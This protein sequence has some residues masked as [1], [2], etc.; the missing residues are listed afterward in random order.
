MTT[1]A[2]VLFSL[3]N[4]KHGANVHQLSTQ[5]QCHTRDELD[6]KTEDQHAKKTRIPWNAKIILMC[7]PSIDALDVRKRFVPIVW[8]N[9]TA[10]NTVVRAK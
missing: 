2:R 4:T 6:A 7:Q 8:L 10:R 5:P 9:C 3:H 1:I